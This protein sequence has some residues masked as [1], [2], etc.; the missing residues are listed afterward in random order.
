M[1]SLFILIPV[2][3]ILLLV[4]IVAWLWC[5]RNEQFDD[6]ESEGQRILFEDDIPPDQKPGEKSQ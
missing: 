2:T 4:A 3:F 6:L 1:N 5:I